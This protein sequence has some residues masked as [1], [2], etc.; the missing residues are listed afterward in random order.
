MH[1]NSAC[2]HS[3]IKAKPFFVISFYNG[4]TKIFN[5]SKNFKPSPE[6]EVPSWSSPPHLSPLE[7]VQDCELHVPHVSNRSCVHQFRLPLSE[8]PRS[9]ERSIEKSENGRPSCRLRLIELIE[10]SKIGFDYN[11]FGSSSDLFSTDECRQIL[12]SCL[13]VL[14]RA[15][16]DFQDLSILEEACRLMNVLPDDEPISAHC[17]L[18]EK[19]DSTESLRLRLNESLVVLLN[20]YVTLKESM[21][22]RKNSFSDRIISEVFDSSFDA[23]LF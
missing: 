2:R 22:D 9:P 23:S 16:R 4:F 14:G 18:D 21:R 7:K 8:S 19:N 5:F 20:H 11:R 10:K 6:M 1:N 15:Y 12:L 3:H 13:S 17:T